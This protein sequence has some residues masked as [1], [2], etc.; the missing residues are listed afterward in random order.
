MAMISPSHESFNESLSTLHFARRAKNIRNRPKI[1]EDVDHKALIRQYEVE[2]KKLR[3]ELDEKNRQIHSNEIVIQLE[4]QKKRAEEDKDAAIFAL[5]QASK[6]YLQEREEKKLLERK[7][8]MMNSQVIVG[9]HKIEDTPQ[10]RSALEERQTML[11]KE[12][13]QKLQE[14]EKERQQIEEDKAQ[15]E[16]YK[17]LLLKQRDIMI[18]LTTKL[19]ERDEAIVQLQ[20]ELDAYDKINR[21]QEDFIE[22][23]NQRLFLIE[24]IMRRNNI[25]IP[26]DNIN[27]VEKEKYNSR[28][29]LDKV[30]IPYEVEQNIKGYENVPMTLL[31]GDEKIRE[32]KS[33]VKDQEK[34]INILKIVSQKFINSAYNDNSKVN[35]N[36]FLNKTEKDY[37]INV[38]IF[39]INNF[40]IK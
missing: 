28:G 12:F 14:F 27:Q 22:N 15:V 1:N 20:E 21:E 37:E 34:E 29:K 3:T 35:L 4:E 11:L 18:A 38:R 8:Q 33:I 19:N 36:E 13:D 10:F 17:Q 40:R 24:N 5:E 6:Q 39:D 9:G 2:L 25:K 7:I 30:Y 26:D 23:K 32:L 31:S 16:R